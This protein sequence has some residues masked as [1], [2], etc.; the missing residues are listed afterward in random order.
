M[1]PSSTEN[2]VLPELVSIGPVTIHTYGLLVALGILAAVGLTEHL[3]RRGGGE[4]GRIIDMSF[5]V[6]FSGLVGAR[7]I[8]VI[9]HLTYYA[10]N[11][12]EILMIW[13]GGLVFY[14]GLIG[15]GTA[16]LAFVHF[17]R[18]P[19]LD[20][21]DIGSAG[22]AIGHAFGRI[23]CFAAGCCYGHFSDLPWA[24]TFTDPRC[25]AVE[26][27]NEPVH[28]TQLYSFIF[29]SVLTAF[30]V[31]L[32]PR[33]KFAG[34]MAAIYLTLYGLFRFGVEFLRGDPRTSMEIFGAAFSVS[35][36]L[37]LAAFAVGAVTYIIL[38]RRSGRET[39]V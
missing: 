11:P 17:L 12:L 19:L 1:S 29:L 37:S 18:L 7:L 32:H 25:L 38:A 24:V 4:P 3:S 2:P 27:L 6:V 31:W 33:R 22:V 30:L 16:F 5:I 10:D 34:Q 39:R 15:G 14:G 9:T 20:M 21:V 8:F 13:K 26:V 36:C 28:P 35:Q 23:G